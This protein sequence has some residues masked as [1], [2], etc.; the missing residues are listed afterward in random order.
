[1]V[2]THPEVAGCLTVDTAVGSLYNFMSGTN[3]TRAATFLR[4]LITT[5]PGSNLEIS[6]RHDTLTAICTVLQELM[7]REH[8][9]Q[10]NPDLSDL[11][12]SIEPTVDSIGDIDKQGVAF[13][14][15]AE[16]K[17]MMLR[18]QGLLLHEEEDEVTGVTTTVATSTYSRRVALLGTDMITISWTLQRSKSSLPKMKFEAIIRN[19]CH[20]LT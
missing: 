12:D 2:I 11:I 1:M 10:F 3:G 4:R 7:K 8:R 14:V 19:F 20:P 13:G 15:V 17:A 6:V 5:L 9:A 18:A 16:L